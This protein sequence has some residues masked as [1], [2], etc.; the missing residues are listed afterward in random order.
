M[1]LRVLPANCLLVYCQRTLVERLGL[2][3]AP[4]AV[5]ERGETVE[6]AGD[7]GVASRRWNGRARSAA[8]PRDLGP[9]RLLQ[10]AE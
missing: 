8:R 6:G 4:L 3:V 2:G 1:D 7:V 10:A 5:M 9:N